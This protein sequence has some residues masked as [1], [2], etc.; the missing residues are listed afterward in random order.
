[1]MN[2]VRDEIE[3]RFALQSDYAAYQLQSIYADYPAW[4]IRLSDGEYGAIVEYSGNEI[5]ESFA[6]TYLESKKLVLKGEVE[7]Q[8]LMLSCR[9]NMLRKQFATLCENFVEPGSNGENRNLVTKEPLKWW[10]E[11]CELLG[12]KQTEDRI[13]DLIAE[14]SA[15]LKLCNIGRS[16]AYWTASR[17]N[18][19]DIE[20]EDSSY[21]IKASVKK[22]ITT[23]HVSSQFQ[24]KSDKPLYLIFTRL[25][26]SA[27]GKSIDDLLTE[28]AHYQYRQVSEYNNY[29]E[30]KG[31]KVGNHGRKR[32]FAILERR[33]YA[34]DESFPG[35]RDEMF[36]EGKLPNGITHLE[37]DI[38]LDGL[39]YENWK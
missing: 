34:I 38:V 30:E 21:E 24:F 4:V 10:K 22:E 32:K 18:T 17:I 28:L 23:I 29:L 37:Y 14:L 25:E 7:K 36:I 35:I 8:Y 33:K 12:N 16:D 3:S 20:M 11:W 26:E 27:T 1:M 9:N 19:H 39:P 13:Y 15:L 6:G 5:S 2:V 31:L